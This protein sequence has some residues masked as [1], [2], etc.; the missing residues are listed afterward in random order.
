[1][2]EQLDGLRV[3][4][5]AF[6]ERE[7]ALKAQYLEM[8]TVALSMKNENNAVDKAR[9]ALRGQLVDMQYELRRSQAQIKE[10]DKRLVAQ[11]ARIGE[12]KAQL[13]SMTLERDEILSSTSWKLTAPARKAISAARRGKPS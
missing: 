13:E 6:E 5:R 8:Q 9:D 12:L 10:R 2:K 7:E 11:D 3:L 1:L 4:V